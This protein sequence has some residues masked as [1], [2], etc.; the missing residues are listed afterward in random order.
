MMDFEALV[1]TLPIAAKGMAGV[2]I[3]IVAIWVSIA[4]MARI[5]KG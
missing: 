3:V 2:F 1:S 4:L 5:F